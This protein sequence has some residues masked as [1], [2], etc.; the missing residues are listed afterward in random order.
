MDPAIIV[1]FVLIYAL[2]VLLSATSV[3]PLSIAALVGALLAA[4]FGLQYDVFTYETAASFIDVRLLS[5]IIGTMIVVEVAEKSG[6]FRFGALYAVKIS[7]GNPSRLFVLVCVVSAVVSMF[8]SDPTALLLMAAATVTISKLLN[9]DPIPYFISAT[10]MINLGGTST[11]IGSTS[12]MVI[13]LAA[14]LSFTDFI[15]YLAIGEIALWAITIL[16]LYVIFKRRLGV[17]KSLP[18]YDP[19]QSIENKK[20]FYQSIFIL[21]LLVFLF[22]FVDTLGIGPE[23]VGLGCAILAL[24]VSNI[25]PAEIFK[26]LDWE[27]VFF[28]AGFMFLMG[29]V[30]ETGILDLVS[31]QLFQLVGGSSMNTALVTLWFSGLGSTVVSNIAIALTF[32]PIINNFSILNPSLRLPISS[33]LVLG[34][35][36]GGATTPLSGSVA[37]MAMGTLKREGISMSFTEFTKIGL[38]TSMLQLAFAS[39]YLLVRFGLGG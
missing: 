8:L 4:W 3:V 22:L 26:G 18:D 30:Q 14:G 35:N 33:A 39:L 24:I 7:R 10:I 13:G 21:I 25:D 9:Y 31:S 2:T 37:M 34:T 32:V 15:G 36:L 6:L 27:T 38:I 5:L 16:T 11:L 12:N 28:I 20:F 29:G 17:K 23:A 19:W 1:I